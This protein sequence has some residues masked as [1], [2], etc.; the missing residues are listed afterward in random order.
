[1]GSLFERLKASDHARRQARFY[2]DGLTGLRGFAALWVFLYHAWTIATPRLMI[3]SVGSYSIDFTPF[4]SAGW[5]GVD[6][7]YTLSGFLLAMPFAEAA[8]ENHKGPRFLPYLYR[9]VLRVF[10]AYYTQLAILLILAWAGIAG[11]LPRAGNLLAH[12]LMVHNISFEYFHS[13][14]GIWWTLPV[15]FSFYLVLPILALLLRGRRWPVLVIGAIVATVSYRYFMFQLIAQQSVDYKVWLLEQLPGHIDQ[16]VFGMVAAYFFV[17]SGREGAVN[18]KKGRSFHPEAS[19]LLGIGGM[20]FFFYLLYLHSSRYW[21][22]QFLLFIWHGGVGFFIAL[23][24]YGIA[25][26]SLIGKFL[27]GNPFILGVGVISYSLY[28]WHLL[29]LDWMRWGLLVNDKGYLFP[30]LLMVGLPLSLGAAMLSY[31]FVERP[32]LFRKTGEKTDRD[33][34]ETAKDK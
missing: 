10:P 29:L 4:F 3:L 18:G 33:S 12:L 13:M 22:G 1:M 20:I 21:N 16:F 9:R 19:L 27:F 32:F 31:L 14:N 5:A 25:S 6:I 2:S 17:K 28:L 11:S 15:E 34:G 7:F 23:L 24:I 8:I 26:N 30:V